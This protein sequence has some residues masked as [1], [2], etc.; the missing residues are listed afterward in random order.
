MQAISAHKYKKQYTTYLVDMKQSQQVNINK[1]A[2]WSRCLKTIKYIQ[3]PYPNSVVCES[4]D[5]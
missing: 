2:A 3:F 4:Y 5:K 1:L